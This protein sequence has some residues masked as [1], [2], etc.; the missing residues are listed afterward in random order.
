MFLI[1]LWSGAQWRVGWK[2]AATVG[3]ACAALIVG[4]ASASSGSDPG[5]PSVS[6]PI[7]EPS[8]SSPVTT[9]TSTPTPPPPSPDPEAKYT[10]NCDLLLNDNFYSSV[11]GW[12]VG[13]AEIHNTGNVGVV[14]RVR[15]TWKQAG[16]APITKVKTTRVGYRHRRA[17]HFKLPVDQNTVEAYQ[18]APGYFGNGACGVKAVIVNSYGPAH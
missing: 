1:W 5:T 6:P 3:F 15:A 18:S 17:V 2:I 14:V 7:S 9:P 13:D 12:L 10:D 4:S 8:S 16:S 11:T